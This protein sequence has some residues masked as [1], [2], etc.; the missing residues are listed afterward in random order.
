MIRGIHQQELLS[1]VLVHLQVNKSR[2]SENVNDLLSAASSPLLLMKSMHETASGLPSR[3][4]CPYTFVSNSPG[5]YFD[6]LGLLKYGLGFC[7]YH[8]KPKQWIVG[9][10]RGPGYCEYELFSLEDFCGYPFGCYCP[11]SDFDTSRRYPPDKWADWFWNIPI[12]VC[13]PVDDFQI[14]K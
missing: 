8:F 12:W 1:S 14:C 5:N 3:E 2:L 7:Y 6:P 4:G 9:P 11:P 10:G 13:W